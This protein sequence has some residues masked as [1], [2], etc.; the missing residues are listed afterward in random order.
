MMKLSVYATCFEGLA[1]NSRRC[2]PRVFL[3]MLFSIS[4]DL[5]VDPLGSP[6]KWDC[7]FEAKATLKLAISDFDRCVGLCEVPAIR[8]LD[9]VGTVIRPTDGGPLLYA[10]S[11]APGR[12]ARPES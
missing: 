6:L 9:G 8:L 12:A 5:H 4:F 1:S 3:K 10:Q 11:S 2:E 7:I